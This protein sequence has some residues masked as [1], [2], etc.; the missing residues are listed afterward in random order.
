MYYKNFRI[1][2]NILRATNSNTTEEQLRVTLTT[3]H[4]IK[5]L[6]RYGIQIYTRQNKRVCNLRTYVSISHIIFK[7]RVLKDQLP[8]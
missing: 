7:E 6:D 2:G 8:G 1:Y 5:A 4:V 3:F